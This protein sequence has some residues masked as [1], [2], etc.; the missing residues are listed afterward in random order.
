MVFSGASVMSPIEVW[1]DVPIAEETVRE[2]SSASTAHQCTNGEILLSFCRQRGVTWR[3]H[4]KLFCT[5]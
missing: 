5:Q 1:E 4:E 3:A 2:E